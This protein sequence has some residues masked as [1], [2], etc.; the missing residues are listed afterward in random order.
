MRFTQQQ[1]S[2]ILEEL[3]NQEDGINQ[4]LKLSLEAIMKAERL[5]HN[6]NCKDVGNGYRKRKS[7]GRGKIMELQIPR[8]RKGNFKPALLALLKDQEEECRRIAFSLY[9]A[10]LTT[11]QVGEMFEELY[12]RHYSSSSVSRMFDYAREEVQNWLD[13]PLDEYYPIIYIDATY[14]PTRRVDS[15]MKEGYYTILGVRADRTREV[16]AIVNFPTESATAWKEV[17]T[18]LKTRG[19]KQT[20]LVVCDGLQG[21]ENSIASSFPKAEVQLCV[22]HLQRNVL[23]YAKPKDKAEIVADFKEVFIMDNTNDS[24]NKAWQRWQNFCRK[25]AKKYRSIASMGEN[26]RYVLYFTCFNYDYR[27]RN[28]IYTTNW[29]ERLNRDY[30]RVT[31]MRGALPNPQATLL[32][33]ARVAMTRK[34]YERK[35]PKLNY[36]NQ[37]FNWED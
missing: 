20:N 16:L 8:T 9:G 3:S 29:I 26:E 10:G 1:I 35:I 25:W 4:L 7:L 18:Q 6:E 13:R 24:Q 30:K 11:E 31:K 22:V 36:E 17:F 34:A 23:K 19:V 14:I 2:T 27:I 28:M 37:K 32:L 21:I 15:V 5:E 12:G 33:L